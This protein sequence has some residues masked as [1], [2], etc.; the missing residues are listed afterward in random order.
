[1]NSNNHF[2]NN[3]NY[4]PIPVKVIYFSK[5]RIINENQFYLNSTFRSVL[6]YFNK[7]IKQEGKTRLKNEYIYNNKIINPNELLINL[8]QIK[9]NSSS[10]TIES[11][12]ILIEIEESDI[13]GDE[14]IPNFDIIIQP[15]I[16]P[17]G[18]FVYKIKEG[19]INLQ[20]YPYKIYEKYELFKFN[21]FSAY[22]NSPKSLFISGGKCN[23]KSIK[24]F[25]IINNQKFSIIKKNLPIEKSNHSIIYI[26]LKD[27]EYIF[28]AGGD[29]LS[30]FYYN[31]KNDCFENW[32]DMNTMHI[33][34]ALYQYKNYLYCFNSFSNYDNYFER[35]NLSSQEHTWE[36]IF[37]V[38]DNDT[39]DFK[40]ESFGV[41]SCINECILLVGGD[42][43][44]P[45]TLVYDP[46]NNFLSLSEEGKNE[47]IKLS[48]K[49]FYKV[50]NI[51]NVAL[52]STLK[53]KKEIAV[54]NK[55]KQ[56]V[57]LIDFNVSDGISKVK[58]SQND[59]GKIIVKAKIHERLRFE[60]QPTIVSGE[61][62]TISKNDPILNEQEIIKVEE[63]KPYINEN[64][65]FRGR[66]KI[67]KKNNYF[68]LSSSIVYNNLIDLI[69]KKNLENNNIYDNNNI[70]DA[71]IN[72]INDKND[73]NSINIGLSNNGYN[74]N[75]KIVEQ[76]RRNKIIN[77]NYV[78]EKQNNDVNLNINNNKNNNNNINK[79]YNLNI[80]HIEDININNDKNNNINKDYNLNINHIEDL[81]I[82]N[83]KN[84]IINK[85]YNLDINHIENLN[86]NINNDNNNNNDNNG[87]INKGYNLDINHIEN[88]NLNINNNNNDN[89]NDKDNDSNENNDISDYDENEEYEE[90][91]R[92][93]RDPFEFTIKEPV[94]QDIILIE[95]YNLSYYNI[96]NFADYIIQK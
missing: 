43:I 40:T 87:N 20:V 55:I 16:D 50:N 51:H 70:F 31:I 33:K 7:N 95:D 66:T 3:S 25:W 89:D 77:N 30:T 28:M 9:K 78:M 27:M 58:F 60:M 56:T 34:P 90:D 92:Q 39:I 94:E 75:F 19:L 29:D 49:Y 8:I 84:N 64:K 11:V 37:P 57:R 72:P 62:L 17:F 46:I 74:E 12:E 52:P 88:L 47:K 96:N 2:I 93:N 6:D 71:K 21:D 13:L 38:F 65:L 81:H 32:G 67:K 86:L 24:D 73:F 4:H 1:M 61:N 35:T 45:K 85:G 91:E 44:K 54:V 26:R 22:C 83:D 10:S 23:D 76:D 63:L 82:N 48:D 59:Y 80:N 79:G 15:K 18:I 36:K 68:F 53:T 69:V 14:N 41:S 5:K 42:N